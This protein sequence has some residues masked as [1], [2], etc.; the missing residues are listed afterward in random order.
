MLSVFI[1]ISYNF[2][3]RQQNVQRILHFVQIVPS[4]TERTASTP[5]ELNH[6]P[7]ITHQIATE[8]TPEY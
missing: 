4:Q 8:P 3:T 1:I 2:K 6:Q 5:T 7:T